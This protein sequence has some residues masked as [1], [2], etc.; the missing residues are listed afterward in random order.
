MWRWVRASRK[1]E[2]SY[3]LQVYAQICTEDKG[4]HPNIQRHIK[5][6]LNLHSEIS[7]TLLWRRIEGNKSYCNITW[8]L[9]FKEHN[10]LKTNFKIY[11]KI[12][13]LIFV[14]FFSR[15]YE[16]PDFGGKTCWKTSTWSPRRT[17]QCDIQ[18]GLWATNI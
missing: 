8:K 4:T 1:F 17:G 7:F 18:R 2:G 6:D 5:Q 9:L 3:S 11:I 13:L 10:V 16:M 15:C 14:F 12:N